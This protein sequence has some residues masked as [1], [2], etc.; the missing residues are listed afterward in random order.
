MCAL[1]IGIS[2]GTVSKKWI[3]NAIVFQMNARHLLSEGMVKA[4]L[5]LGNSPFAALSSVGWKFSHACPE[6][7]S[8]SSCPR[9]VQRSCAVSG[10]PSCLLAASLAHP[11][12]LLYLWAHSWYFSGLCLS[13]CLASGL[14]P[15]TFPEP[16]TLSTN[17][18]LYPHWDGHHWG[19]M[20]KM[21]CLFGNLS[22]ELP[23]L[24]G[25]FLISTSTLSKDGTARLQ[26][27]AGPY[28]GKIS[29]PSLSGFAI[30]GDH[31]HPRP[32]FL[33]E[34]IASWLSKDGNIEN[35]YCQ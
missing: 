11:P 3:V 25:S 34:F 23:T 16:F 20:T 4:N 21:P 10:L 19:S 26:S 5:W 1:H 14:S 8:R 33:S 31:L 24:Q 29:S 15:N 17:S 9:L 7:A 12:W 30:R 28:T 13:T 32:S 6:S 35:F 27:W 22:E 2:S 18:D